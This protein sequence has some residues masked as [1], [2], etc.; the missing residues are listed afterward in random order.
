MLPHLSLFHRRGQ[1]QQSLGA[2]GV[3]RGPEVGRAGGGR[4]G[5]GGTGGEIVFELAEKMV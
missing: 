1:S 4:V 3:S 2:G 5:G